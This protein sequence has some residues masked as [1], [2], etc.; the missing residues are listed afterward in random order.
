MRAEAAKLLLRDQKDAPL[1]RAPDA[2]LIDAT[3]HE[4]V[5]A[6]YG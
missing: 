6:V 5:G 3:A 2:V 4:P 1:R